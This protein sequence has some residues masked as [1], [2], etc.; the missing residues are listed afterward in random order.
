MEDEKKTETVE[1]EVKADDKLGA[2]EYLAQLDELK[3]NTVSRDK[4]EKAMSDNKKLAN[5]LANGEYQQAK[6]K[7]KE[8]VDIAEL[9]KDLKHNRQKN[10]L[11]LWK[12]I[13]TLRDAR[14]KLDASDDILVADRSRP[15]AYAEAQEFA[16]AMQEAIEDSNGDPIVFSSR[17]R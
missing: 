6:A 16:E 15:G 8:E 3:K 2:D 4:Y 13:L 7:E 14:L 5:A 17:F 9:E 12:K 1:P 11:D 10:D